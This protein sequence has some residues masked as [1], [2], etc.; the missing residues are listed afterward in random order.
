M[1][2]SFTKDG[3]MINPQLRK[4]FDCTT[5]QKR[6]SKEVQF[7]W[8]NPYILVQELELESYEEH[9]DRLFNDKNFR[10]ESI[11]SKK[12]FLKRN[13]ESIRNWFLVYPLGFR[14][15]VRCLEGGAWDR[16]SWKGDFSDFTEALEFAKKVK[17]DLKDGE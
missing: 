14:Y 4:N 5:N 1:R 17:K 8:N 2:H 10:N 16:S 11:E 13:E 3:I 15:T 7:F 12:E 9:F 6:S